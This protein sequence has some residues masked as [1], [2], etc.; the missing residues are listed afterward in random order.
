MGWGSGSELMHSVC[1]ELQKRG[2]SEENRRV[3]YEVLVPAMWDRDWDTESDCYDDDP[4]LLQYFK[5]TFPEWF[6]EE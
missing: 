5:D 1:R 3:F 4:V 2:V 6:E